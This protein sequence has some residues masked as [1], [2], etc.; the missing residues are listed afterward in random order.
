MARRVIFY[1]QHLLGVGHLARASRI[2]Q[3]IRTAGME[4]T[5]VT[6]GLPV[7]GF[8]DEGIDSVQLPPVAAG[9][10]FAG[11]VDAEGV[12]VTQGFLD[13]RR[14]Q[15]LSLFHTLAGFSFWSQADAVRT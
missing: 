6:G 8:P 9:A 14:D 7:P 1:V 5:L 3:A 13:T 12:P 2:A 4:I 15:L 10:G 11:L